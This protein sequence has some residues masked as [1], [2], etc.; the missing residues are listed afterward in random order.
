MSEHRYHLILAFFVT[1][2]LGVAVVASAWILAGGFDRITKT[3]RTVTVRGLAER[4]VDANLA[5]WPMSFSLGGTSLPDIQKSIINQTDIVTAYLQKY[6]LTE[7]DYTVQAPS[8]TNTTLQFRSEQHRYPFIATQ[9]ILVRSSQ[10]QAVKNAQEHVLEL[11]GKDISISQEYGNTIEFEYTNL[12]DI[13]PE[14]IGEATRNAREAANQ[15]ASDSGSQVGKIKNA[16]QGYFSIENA[17]PGLEDKKKIRV[18][19][20]VEYTLSD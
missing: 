9:V 1:L 15:F 18:V 5:I 11:L 16:T 13:K 2:C 19:T 4:E 10:V 20:T 14:M 3:S 8:I 12:N 7:K 6:G 17:A